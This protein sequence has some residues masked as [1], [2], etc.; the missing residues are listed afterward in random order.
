MNK[1]MQF[2]QSVYVTKLRKG[3][4]DA[5]A[6]SA[7]DSA[8]IARDEREHPTRCPSREELLVRWPKYFRVADADC[9]QLLQ[10]WKLFTAHLRRK[11]LQGIYT[12]DC[13]ECV[14]AMKQLDLL[15][16]RLDADCKRER[17]ART[18]EH[19]A[20]KSRRTSDG[21]N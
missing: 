3:A 1:R 20:K 14:A 19:R 10:Y 4:V 5:D 15:N 13:S 16:D 18:L 12:C 17:E 2:W 6:R 7:A 9:E 11:R 21:M 8:V